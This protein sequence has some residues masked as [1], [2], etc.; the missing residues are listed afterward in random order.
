MMT[1]VN[2]GIHH[3][4]MDSV[5]STFGRSCVSYPSIVEGTNGC[6]LTGYQ[7]GKLEI[8]LRVTDKNLEL[9]YTAQLSSGRRMACLSRENLGQFH[10]QGFFGLTAQ[11]KAGAVNDIDL[12]MIDFF[13]LDA[14]YYNDPAFQ[15][16][17]HERDYF[18]ND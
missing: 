16:Q 8:V 1:V 17:L 15:D 18:R 11:N 3:I 14:H 7:G 4:S 6:V 10:Y 2:D 9:S 5:A 12:K 13:N